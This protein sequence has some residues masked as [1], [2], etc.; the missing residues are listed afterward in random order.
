[1]TLYQRQTAAV[2]AGVASAVACGIAIWY[3]GLVSSP[4]AAGIVASLAASSIIAGWRYLS[5]DVYHWPDVAKAQMDE[6]ERQR[7]ERR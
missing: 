4:V 3:V 1:M 5:R 7:N 6:L 2:W